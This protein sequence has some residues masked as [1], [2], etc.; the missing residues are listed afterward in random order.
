[1]YSGFNQECI[2]KNRTRDLYEKIVYLESK[3]FTDLDFISGI[4][5]K[6]KSCDI[7]FISSSIRACYYV[8]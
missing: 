6:S 3:I 4:N 1:M 2:S 5:K 7:F 8:K